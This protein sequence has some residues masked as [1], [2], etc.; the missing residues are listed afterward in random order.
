M[1]I[2]LIIACS[3]LSIEIAY[4]STLFYDI[5]NALRIHTIP[6]IVKAFSKVKFWN[7]L[8]SKYLFPINMTFSIFFTIYIKL[9]EMINCPY[10]LS[11]HLTWVTVYLTQD[12]G[13]LYSVVS[14]LLAIP[15]THIIEKIYT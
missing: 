2:L 12:I 6:D 9:I 3:I 13:L 5:K 15:I 8:T 11:F 1:I 14:G 10:C 4:N 7:K